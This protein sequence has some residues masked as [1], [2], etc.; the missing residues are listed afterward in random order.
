MVGLKCMECG[1][2]NTSREGEEGIPVAAVQL[3]QAAQ[4]RQDAEEWKTEDEGEIVGGHEE[5]ESEEQ[6]ALNDFN[7]LAYAHLN[8]L[9][10]RFSGQP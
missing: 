9:T 4:A 10:F 7:N 1:S 2:Y 6:D 8:L 3:P 5:A